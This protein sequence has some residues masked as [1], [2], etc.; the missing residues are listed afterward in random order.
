MSLDSFPLLHGVKNNNL[1]AE[2]YHRDLSQLFQA[3]LP[4]KCNGGG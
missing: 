1:I 2:N 3:W 4:G